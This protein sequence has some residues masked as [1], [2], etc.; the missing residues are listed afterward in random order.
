MNR[1]DEASEEEDEEEMDVAPWRRGWNLVRT[2]ADANCLSTLT[3]TFWEE[4]LARQAKHNLTNGTI[5]KGPR[6][7][8]L[9]QFP[10]TRLQGTH[11][12]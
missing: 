2:N 6:N 12:T 8:L 5:G 3:S 7:N 1:E 11:T 10:K 4:Y 9:I